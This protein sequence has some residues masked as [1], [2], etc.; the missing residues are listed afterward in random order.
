MTTQPN[1]ALDTWAP[2]RQASLS[3]VRARATFVRRM[4]LGLMVLATITVGVF[5]GYVFS[6]LFDPNENRTLQPESETVT[7]LN[8]RIRGFT[9]DGDLRYLIIAESAAR[10]RSDGSLIDLRSPK[11][12]RDDSS[13]IT[14]IRGTW[15]RDTEIL[16]LNDEVVITDWAGYVLYSSHAVISMQDGTVTGQARLQGTGPLG[17][18]RSDKYELFD[19]GERIRLTG[20]VKTTIYPKQEEDEDQP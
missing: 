16:E 6:G 14:A 19:S 10:R 8:P 5:V 17:D 2:R 4:R 20:N 3:E 18:L 15:N 12:T 11:L 9:E 7:M 13:E 1:N